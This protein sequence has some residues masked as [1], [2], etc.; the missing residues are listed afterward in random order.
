MFLKSLLSLQYLASLYHYT[1]HVKMAFAWCN[2]QGEQVRA[3]TREIVEVNKR[4]SIRQDKIT[5]ATRDLATAEEELANLPA[6]EPPTKELVS[7][8]MNVEV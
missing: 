7:N 6:Y 1:L 3:K 4:E 5:A 8:S 2:V